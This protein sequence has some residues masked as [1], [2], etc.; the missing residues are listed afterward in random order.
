MKL[1][2]SKRA[3]LRLASIRDYISNDSPAVAA[4]VASV[5]VDAALRLEQ[6]PLSG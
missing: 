6:F 2:W 4:R 5:I 3:I 1:L